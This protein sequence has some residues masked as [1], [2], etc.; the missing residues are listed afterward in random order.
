MNARAPGNGRSPSPS[1]PKTTSLDW[2]RT[3]ICSPPTIEG[4][5]VYLVTNRA[6][7]RCVALATAD[8]IWTFD[9][10]R[11]A[12]VHP[13]D[14]SHCSILIHG[15]FLY[16]TPSNGVDNTHCGMPAPDAPSLIVLDKATGR[17]LARDRV[18]IGTRTIHSAW[19]SPSLGIVD[20]RPLIFL[21]GADGICYAFEALAAAPPEGQLATLKEVWRFDCDPAAPKVDVL[22]WQDNRREGPINITGMPV[23]DNG[24]VYVTAGGDYWHGKPQCWLKCIDAAKGTEIWSYPLSRHCLST[25]AIHDGLAYIVD[26]GRLIHCVDIATGKAV[27]THTANGDFWSSPLVADGRVYVGSRR[28]DFWILAAGRQK[29]ILACIDLEAPINSTAVAANGVLFIATDTKLY[30]VGKK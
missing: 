20:G 26:C 5:R 22:K 3:G 21:G 16:I 15:Q 14:A 30:A 9:L 1:W 19:A 12:G 18:R 27:W 17:M 8:P 13:H 23:F 28:G 2:P 29:K 11:Q 10:R 25:P 24:R 4:Q 6:E 7:V